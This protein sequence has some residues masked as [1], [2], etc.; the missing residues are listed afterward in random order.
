MEGVQGLIVARG[1][2]PRPAGLPS[3]PS[4]P[5]S[6]VSFP[7]SSPQVGSSPLVLAFVHADSVLGESDLVLSF[8]QLC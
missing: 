6:S 2:M 4:H 8:E 3:C 1:P 7:P 5:W